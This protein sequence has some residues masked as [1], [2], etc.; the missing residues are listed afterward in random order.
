MSG[1]I[2]SHCPWSAAPILLWAC[3]EA[4]HPGREYGMKSTVYLM[5]P[6]AENV[7]EGGGP[8][9]PFKGTL[10]VA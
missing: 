1:F 4:A 5:A 2:Q 8:H 7:R 9:V 6:E 3:G 10:P